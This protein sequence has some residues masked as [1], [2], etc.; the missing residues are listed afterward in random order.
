MPKPNR[1][2]TETIKD[3][4]IYVY[5]PS[6]EMVEDWK[7]RAERAGVSLSKFIVERVLDS[8]RRE[9][10]E[11][12]YL[13]RAELIKRLRSAEE[14]LKRLRDENRLLRRLV[15]NLDNEL[16]RYRAQPFLE[17]RFEGIRR[18]D[19]DLIDLLRRGG[20]FSEEEILAQLNI[21]PS[22]TDLV[23]AVAKQLE[24]LEEY[25]LVEFTGRGWRWRG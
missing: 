15:E 2:K 11:E 8:I 1:G 20:T 17:E 25:G 9:D 23:K 4:T 10:G 7:F 19:K 22:D 3:R 21:S 6:L 14:E 18:F 5:L 24:I 13:S 12:G 16:R